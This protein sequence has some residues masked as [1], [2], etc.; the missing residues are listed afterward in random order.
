MVKSTNAGKYATAVNLERLGVIACA[1]IVYLHPTMLWSS[2]LPGHVRI[3]GV[4]L[5]VW[6]AA[7]WFALALAIYR[8]QPLAPILALCIYVVARAGH[9]LYG[10]MGFGTSEDVPTLLVTTILIGFLSVSV[11]GAVQHQ[12]VESSEKTFVATWMRE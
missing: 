1:L 4:V 3:I 6:S 5:S 8:L 12:R 9:L 2:E 7:M 11:Y 10:T